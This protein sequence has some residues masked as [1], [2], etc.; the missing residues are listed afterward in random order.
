MKFQC[1]ESFFF[2]RHYEHWPYIRQSKGFSGMYTLCSTLETAIHLIKFTWMLNENNKNIK[3]NRFDATCFWELFVKLY[4]P[5][6]WNTKT[7][8]FNSICCSQGTI[9]TKM[10]VKSLIF[11]KQNFRVGFFHLSGNCLFPDIYA[12][13]ILMMHIKFAAILSHIH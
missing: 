4:F 10:L 9:L 1:C 2:G 8:T 13:C 5:N 7:L 3:S 6:T 11:L 12:L